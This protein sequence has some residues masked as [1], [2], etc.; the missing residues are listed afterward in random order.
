MS[1]TTLIAPEQRVPTDERV[2][3]ISSDGHATAR[4]QDY[5]PYIPAAYHEEF[6]AFCE[7][8]ARE[9]AHTTDPESLRQRLDPELVQEWVES[10]LEP[11]REH[12]QYDPAQRQAQLDHE[13]I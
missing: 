12:G 4:M 3:V 5:R 10:V 2:L 6:D 13:G 9:G 1:Q 7:A 8:F 11:G